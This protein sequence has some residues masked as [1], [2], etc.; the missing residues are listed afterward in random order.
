MSWVNANGLRFHV[1]QLGSTGD[2]TVIFLHGLVMD[3]MS[4]WY[5]TVANAVARNE[6]VVLYDLRGHGLSERPRSGYT[7]ED[8]VEDLRCLLD[9]LEID[10]PVYL[11]GNSYGGLVS[12]A[13]TRKFPERVAGLILVEAHFP[14][15][16]WGE[17]V[18]G[19]LEV[20]GVWIDKP[21]II[22]WREENDQRHHRRRFAAAEDFIMKTSLISDLRNVPPYDESDLCTIT[23]P[24]LAIYGEHSD[25]IERGQELASWLPNC[26]LEILPDAAHSILMDRSKEVRAYLLEWLA[27]QPQPETGG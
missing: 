13:F 18:A 22:A 7:V 26:R 8:S 2:K 25:V 16:G 9:A 5:Y 17:K 6:R 15:E 24:A 3:N 1:Q 12:L 14:V 10:Q 21:T 23:C 20:G 4:S 19:T 27:K 11:A